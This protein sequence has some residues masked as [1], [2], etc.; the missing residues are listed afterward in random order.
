M[1]VFYKGDAFLAVRGATVAP[2]DRPVI[3]FSF[4]LDDSGTSGLPVVTMAGFIAPLAQWDVVE[5]AT[6]EIMNRYEVPVFHAKEFHDTKPPFAKWS[7][8]KKRTFVDEVFTAAD[9]RIF[10]LSM[11]VRKSAHLAA[12]SGGMLPS[13][14]PYGVCF[15]ALVLRAV[16]D[17]QVG[18]SVRKDGVSFLVESGNKNNAELE[19]MFHNFSTAPAFEGA[20]RS[21]TFIPKGSC[22]AIQIAD[23]FAFYSRRFRAGKGCPTALPHGCGET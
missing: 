16:L 5:P 13:M 7:K 19:E 8:I 17:P 2:P 10:G 9:G 3:V 14:S 20:L 6:H 22:R 4:Y 15:S 18:P 1:S 12:Q 23:L 11:T 21:L